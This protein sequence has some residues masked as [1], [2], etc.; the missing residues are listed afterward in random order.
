VLVG[1][2]AD[3]GHDEGKGKGDGEGLG[4]SALVEIAAASGMRVKL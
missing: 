2:Y 3:N 4:S 1:G